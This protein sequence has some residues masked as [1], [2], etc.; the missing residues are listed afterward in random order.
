MV[1][2]RSS[3]DYFYRTCERE[4]LRFSTF[5]RSAESISK[6]RKNA[7]RNL[8]VGCA[9]THRQTFA[10]RKWTPNSMPLFSAFSAATAAITY[11]HIACVLL[12]R[13]MECAWIKSKQT[14][15]RSFL[16]SFVRS[17]V[18]ECHTHLLRRRRHHHHHHHVSFL[19]ASSSSSIDRC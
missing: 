7:K 4:K 19:L 2:T 15:A 13:C 14:C 3:R 1:T 10:N 16:P 11:V 6:R 9:R 17:S 5:V 12:A 18:H 8:R